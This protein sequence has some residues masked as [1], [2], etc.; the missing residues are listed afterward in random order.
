MK[1]LIFIL[2]IS[3]TCSGCYYEKKILRNSSSD[4]EK[5]VILT[6]RNL[7]TKVD[8][9]EIEIDNEL[10]SLNLYSYPRNYFGITTIAAREDRLV[11][12]LMFSSE[13]SALDEMEISVKYSV[14][15]KNSFEN[16]EIVLPLTEY[17]KISNPLLDERSISIN[18][19]IWVRNL[20]NIDT[21]S[22]DD[23]RL[24][25]TLSIQRDVRYN[26]DSAFYIVNPI[27][28]DIIIHEKDDN[29]LMFSA[30]LNCN[31]TMYDVYSQSDPLPLIPIIISAA[32]SISAYKYRKEIIEKGKDLKEKFSIF[33]NKVKDKVKGE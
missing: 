18:N 17:S 15:N 23:S 1:N 4:F 19:D 22:F 13:N 33:I 11:M 32:A 7:N 14:D 20:S 8:T 27:I 31:G 25:D 5:H 9:S 24:K 28:Q 3:M 16:F 30:A 29:V 26:I 2:F 6:S 10:S 21:S 12:N